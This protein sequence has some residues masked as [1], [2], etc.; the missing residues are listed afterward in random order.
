MLTGKGKLRT[1]CE[2]FCSKEGPHYCIEQSTRNPLD[3]IKCKESFGNC[4]E[5]VTGQAT[6]NLDSQVWTSLEVSLPEL[7]CIDLAE[8]YV[9][10]ESSSSRILRKKKMYDLQ[11]P[12]G[13]LHEKP[14]AK[15]EIEKKTGCESTTWF[16]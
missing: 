11:S 12:N 8:A 15:A 9:T 14:L 7:Y 3:V 4:P 5:A 1:R 16:P 2:G 13:P 6:I 10:Q